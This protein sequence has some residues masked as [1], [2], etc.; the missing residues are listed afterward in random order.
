MTEMQSAIPRSLDP[1]VGSEY[2]HRGPSYIHSTHTYQ[3]PF[4]AGSDSCNAGVSK[5]DIVPDLVEFTVWCQHGPCTRNWN[6][7]YL[8]VRMG[9]CMALWGHVASGVGSP[10]EPPK[11]ALEDM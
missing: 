3:Q 5:I 4:G 7:D 6:K 10:E 9:S 1:G 11:E 8:C 2:I